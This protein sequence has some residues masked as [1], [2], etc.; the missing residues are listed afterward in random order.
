PRRT[1]PGRRGSIC[2]RRADGF[3]NLGRYV[4]HPDHERRLFSRVPD[5]LP[6]RDQLAVRGRRGGKPSGNA[7]DAHAAYR[8][9]L[10]APAP[11]TERGPVPRRECAGPQRAPGVLEYPEPRGVVERG[12]AR[13][14]AF[15]LFDP[16]PLAIAEY[17]HM[18]SASGPDALAVHV[19]RRMDG[20]VVDGEGNNLVVAFLADHRGPSRRAPAV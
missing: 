5:R 2:C 12:C 14:E 16:R 7:R 18:A 15:V 8:G 17:D 19:R 6:A 10:A 20:A 4:P 1:P 11:R 13:G 3:R 9:S